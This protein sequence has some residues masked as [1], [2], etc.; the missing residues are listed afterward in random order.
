MAAV[1]LSSLAVGSGAHEH[2]HQHH[3]STGS[4]NDRKYS[5][6]HEWVSLDGDVGTIGITDFAQ[7]AL[8]DIIYLQLPQVGAAMALNQ[9]F[10]MVE[11]VKVTSD[12]FSPVDGEVVARNEQAVASPALINQSPYE[13]GW[14]VRVTVADPHQRDTLMSGDEY[15]TWVSRT[16]G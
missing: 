7:A 16:F 15:D 3:G 6:T 11:S 1:G 12:I 14:L 13:Q 4:P 5:K 9:T 8:G 10:G 2:H